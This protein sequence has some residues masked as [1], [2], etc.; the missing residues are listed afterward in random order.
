MRARLFIAINPPEKLRD[1]LQQQQYRLFELGLKVKWV[2]RE[3]L[4]LTLEFLGDTELAK[5]STLRNILSQAVE[6]SDALSLRLKGMGAFPNLHQ[7]RVIWAGLEGQVSKLVELQQRIRQGLQDGGLPFDRKPFNPHLTLGRVKDIRPG[8]SSE[9]LNQ[10]I[11]SI[12]D[13]PSESWSVNRV[14]LMQSELGGPAPRYTI[15]ESFYL[16]G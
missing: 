2:E 9:H 1:L 6:S 7:P 11:S 14:D 3:N 16:K 13:Q 12:K 5:L 4:H 8:F 10:V 15:L